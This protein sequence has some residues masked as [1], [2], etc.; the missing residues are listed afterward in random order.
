[1]GNNREFDVPGIF[2]GVLLI[3]HGGE[4]ITIEGLSLSALGYQ[5][6]P[7][8][9]SQLVGN[10]REFDVSG[11]FGGVLLIVHGGELI[12]IEN[13][14]LSALGYQ[15]LPLAISQLVVIIGNLM[16]QAFLEEFY[17]LFVEGSL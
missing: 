5:L 15:L 8:A 12:T 10:N 9:T 1:M 16:F 3:V 17:S 6:L 13:P 2:G 11:I 7:L 4:L 14:S